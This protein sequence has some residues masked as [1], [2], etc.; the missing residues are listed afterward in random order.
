MTTYVE[1]KSNI[2]GAIRKVSGLVAG[3]AQLI[4][5]SWRASIECKSLLSMSDEELAARRLS[6]QDVG[7]YLL[8]DLL[9]T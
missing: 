6:R 4:A 8:K 2:P 3:A 5:A 9:D 7:R 1:A